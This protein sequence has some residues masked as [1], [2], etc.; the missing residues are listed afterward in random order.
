MS[1]EEES[2]IKSLAAEVAAGEKE[3]AA[4]RKS[5]AG[6]QAKADQLT[7]AMEAAGGDKLRNQKELVD[8]MLKVRMLASPIGDLHNP[9]RLCMAKL[10]RLTAYSGTSNGCEEL[11][12]V[13][14]LILV[15]FEPCQEAC[16][17]VLRMR[18]GLNR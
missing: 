11:K 14:R 15:T 13:L 1:A 12:S 16:T 3:L 4:L 5:A 8:Q 6:L 17:H 7:A 18:R 10:T 9:P 2:R